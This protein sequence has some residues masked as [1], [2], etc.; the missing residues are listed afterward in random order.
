MSNTV[1][2]FPPAAIIEYKAVLTDVVVKA[3][4]GSAKLCSNVSMRLSASQFIIQACRVP[5]SPFIM[6]HILDPT[7]LSMSSIP[8]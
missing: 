5:F 4:K 2:M 3:N 6:T 1:S 8:H 7:H